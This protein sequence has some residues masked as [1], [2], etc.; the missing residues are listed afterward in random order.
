MD[1]DANVQLSFSSLH[2]SHTVY[3]FQFVNVIKIV[4][5][6]HKLFHK[7]PVCEWVLLPRNQ[8]GRHLL[9]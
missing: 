5:I 2:Q 8:R 3:V 9:F 1:D 6:F 4:V 7:Q